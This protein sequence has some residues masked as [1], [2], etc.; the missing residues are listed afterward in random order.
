MVNK[1]K[2]MTNKHEK[3]DLKKYASK[4]ILFRRISTFDELDK[5]FNKYYV[6]NYL[7]NWG[8]NQTI[9]YFP[10][11]KKKPFNLRGKKIIL[12]YYPFFKTEKE[13]EEQNV[14]FDDL[15]Q[16]KDKILEKLK[17][18]ELLPKITQYIISKEKKETHG[19]QV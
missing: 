3:E 12:T 16:A 14:L 9:E 6:I 7:H 2:N 11:L 17:E 5:Y 19:L 18:K 8:H 1:K 13:N 10:Y 4:N 15:N